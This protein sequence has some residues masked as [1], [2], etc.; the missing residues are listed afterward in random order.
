MERVLSATDDVKSKF[1]REYTQELNDLKE[2]HARELEQSKNH[3]VDIYE[4]RV[5]P[6]RERAEEL[7]RRLTRVESDLRDKTRSK[8]ELMVELRQLQKQCDE[9]IG[10]LK[11]AVLAKSDELQRVLHLYEDNL[12]LVKEL[13][14]ENESLRQK[15]ELLRTEYYK[16]EGLQR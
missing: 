11:L 14:L 15:Q 3:L 5:D 16:L 12:T 9:E 7:E 13:R 8:D 10:R 6:W 4:R 1:D 2:R